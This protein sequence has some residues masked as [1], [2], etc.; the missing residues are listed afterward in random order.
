MAWNPWRT[1]KTRTDTLLGVVDLPERLG[2]AV[3]IPHPGGDVVLLD[4][5]LTQRQRSRALAHEL[6]H[7]ERGGGADAPGMPEQW[8]PVVARDEQ[9]TD[10]E[11]ITRLVPLGDLARWARRRLTAGDTVEPHQV[12]EEWHVTDDVALRALE[13]TLSHPTLRAMVTAATPERTPDPG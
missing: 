12:A 13:L 2:G 1:L 11:A 7:L 6:V 5:S 3:A 8:K 4:R 9:Q 10:D